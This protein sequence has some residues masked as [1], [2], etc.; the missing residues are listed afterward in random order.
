MHVALVISCRSVELC[1]AA[2]LPSFQPIWLKC[3]AAN[4]QPVATYKDTRIRGYKA[5]YLPV[6]VFS[7]VGHCSQSTDVPPRLR[8]WKMFNKIIN[9][10]IVTLGIQSY[11]RGIAQGM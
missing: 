7:K 6:T 1:V 2:S 11:A 9:V 10:R 5:V 3:F 4:V 8:A